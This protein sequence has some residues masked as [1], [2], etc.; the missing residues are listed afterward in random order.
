MKPERTERTRNTP[1]VLG[2][3]QLHF[4]LTH[5][6]SSERHGTRLQNVAD[7]PKVR[8]NPKYNGYLN[9][10]NKISTK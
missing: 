9:I 6:T 2:D 8:L 4:F 7:L 5:K 3:I 1:F 10:L